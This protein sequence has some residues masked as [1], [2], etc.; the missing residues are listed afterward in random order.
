MLTFLCA[1]CNVY[2]MFYVAAAASCFVA[3]VCGG[4]SL[5]TTRGVLLA[6]HCRRGH[7]DA[8]SVLGSSEQFNDSR[9]ARVQDASDNAFRQR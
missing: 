4:C 1:A 8:C 7:R 6:L 3:D 9:T 5:L 2:A